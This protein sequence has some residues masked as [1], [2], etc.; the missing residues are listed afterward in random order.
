MTRFCPSVRIAA[1]LV[2]AVAASALAGCSVISPTAPPARAVPANAEVRSPAP[3]VVAIGDSITHGRGVTAAQAWPRLVAHKRGWAMTDLGINGAGFITK[4]HDGGT[5]DTEIG[6]VAA[7]D[8]KLILISGSR[9]D[10]RQ[11]DE[12]LAAAVPAELLKLR[13]SAPHAVIV[14]I[15][16][17]WNDHA[18]PAK[19]GMISEQVRKAAPRVH[20]VYLDIGQPFADRRQ[21]LQ[22]DDVHP[23]AVGQQALAEAIDEALTA[24]HVRL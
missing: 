12:A 7:L 4:G 13:A 24:A 22:A 1:A 20:A 8:P 17:I 19:L 6:R 5:F 23:T 16:A 18:A 10:L 21:L 9:N 11:P 14:A 3:V 2:L 15:S